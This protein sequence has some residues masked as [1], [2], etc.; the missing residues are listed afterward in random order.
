MSLISKEVLSLKY[1]HKPAKI[2]K[3]LMDNDWISEGMLTRLHCL[4]ENSFILLNYSFLL[5]NE[6]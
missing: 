6:H 4:T 5:L 2:S 1:K 3:M